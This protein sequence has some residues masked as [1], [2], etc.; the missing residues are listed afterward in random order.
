VPESYRPRAGGRRHLVQPGDPFAELL[1]PVYGRLP[2]PLSARR[3]KRR[4]GLAAPAVEHRQVFPVRAGLGQAAAKRVERADA[5]RRQT[6]AG[7]EA[8]GGGDADPQ[9]GEGAG[10][11][12][13]RDQRDL[14][15]TSSRRGRLLDFGEQAF[16][17]AR[18]ALL[19]ETEPGFVDDLTAAPGAGDRVEGRGVE[20][21]D[22]L[23]CAA[24]DAARP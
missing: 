22:E 12:A 4:E 10:A 5:A 15:P 14:I 6:E 16:G 24:R 7:G 18:L 3:V 11:E 21:D 8:G 19:G 2:D 13:D 9:A 1:G 23:R 20:P 17:V